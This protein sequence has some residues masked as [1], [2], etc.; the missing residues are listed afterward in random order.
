MKNIVLQFPM[1]VVA[2]EAFISAPGASMWNEI[3][4]MR[5]RYFGDLHNLFPRTLLKNG[6][7]RGNFMFEMVMEG[8]RK[9]RWWYGTEDR[10]IVAVGLVKGD[11]VEWGIISG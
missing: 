6:T 1:I 9:E 4:S 5:P 11:R 2:T 8:L 7:D 10:K 3:Y